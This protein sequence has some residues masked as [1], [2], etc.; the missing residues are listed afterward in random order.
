MGHACCV[1]RRKFQQ[2]FC[3]DQG[4]VLGV[5]LVLA[6]WIIQRSTLFQFQKIQIVSW[7]MIFNDCHFCCWKDFENWMAC[8]ILYVI[9]SLLACHLIR[10]SQ[11]VFCW[12]LVKLVM[13]PTT[14]VS[15][16]SLW[17]AYGSTHQMHKAQELWQCIRLQAMVFCGR[18]MLVFRNLN[19]GSPG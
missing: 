2:L 18:K 12:N 9:N 19:P 10:S 3:I 4:E 13:L 14:R 17:E 5:W 15:P 1:V 11:V 16:R 7:Q 8:P 6:K